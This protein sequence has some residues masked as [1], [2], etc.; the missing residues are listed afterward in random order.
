M[1]WPGVRLGGAALPPRAGTRV[2]AA[3]RFPTLRFAVPCLALPPR[4]ELFN[5]RGGEEWGVGQYLFEKP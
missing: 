2:S 4:S 3:L 1:I 5:Y